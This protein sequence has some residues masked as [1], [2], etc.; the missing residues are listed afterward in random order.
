MFFDTMMQLLPYSYNFYRFFFC[1]ALKNGRRPD[2]ITRSKLDQ[3]E[4]PELKK[5]DGMTFQ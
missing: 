1:I 3:L 2:L 5:I 4:V